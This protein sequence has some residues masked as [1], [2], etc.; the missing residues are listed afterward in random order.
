MSDLD[1]SHKDDPGEKDKKDKKPAVVEPPYYFPWMMMLTTATPTQMWLSAQVPTSVPTPPPAT[2]PPPPPPPSV[3]PQAVAKEFTAL[4]KAIAKNNEDMWAAT[5]LVAGKVQEQERTMQAIAHDVATL[6][7][8][9]VATAPL[10]LVT[11]KMQ[12]KP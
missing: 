4:K 8:K 12:R 7:G 5:R 9:T 6:R 11:S 3:D 2:T 1:S 10:A